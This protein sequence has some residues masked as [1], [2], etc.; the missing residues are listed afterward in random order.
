MKFLKIFLRKIKTFYFKKIRLI[1]LDEIYL[2]IICFKFFKNS[3]I[4][5]IQKFK[6]FKKFAKNKISK[7]HVMNTNT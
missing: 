1:T 3:K 2:I 5:K 7:I 4:S 6:I